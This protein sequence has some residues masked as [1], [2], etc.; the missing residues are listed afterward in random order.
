MGLRPETQ[1]R[2]ILYHFSITIYILFIHFIIIIII[3][4]I[5]D[6]F[7]QLTNTQNSS[8]FST[9]YDSQISFLPIFLPTNRI[10]ISF[11]QIL[12]S[13]NTYIFLFVLTQILS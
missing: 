8:L 11:D 10:Q 3:I 4:I 2:T 13:N 1:P 6:T 12:S 5:F 9:I 7:Y